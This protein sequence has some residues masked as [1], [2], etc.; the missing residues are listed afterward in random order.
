MTIT[1]INA[2]LTE[3]LSETDTLSTTPAQAMPHRPVRR[4]RLR[5]PRQRP[6]RRSAAGR[7]R[8]AGSIAVLRAASRSSAQRSTAAKRAAIGFDTRGCRACR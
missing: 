6:Q 1:Q 7:H 4:W 3:V 5:R 2:W 8:D